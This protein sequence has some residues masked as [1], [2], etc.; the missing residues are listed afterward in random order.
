VLR[1]IRL[2]PGSLKYLDQI[3][4][5]F[6]FLLLYLVL[7]AAITY[8]FAVLAV[9]LFAGSVVNPS[10]HAGNPQY[11]QEQHAACDTFEEAYLIL[12]QLTTQNN[13]NEVNAIHTRA[14]GPWVWFFFGTYIFLVSIV[15]QDIVTGVVMDAF[16]HIHAESDA[17]EEGWEE[18]EEEEEEGGGGGEGLRM[19]AAENE[20]PTM[21][22]R[23]LRV[24]KAATRFERWFGMH[25]SDITEKESKDAIRW[26][27][28]ALL[29]QLNAAHR[30]FKTRERLASLPGKTRKS[31]ASSRGSLPPKNRNNPL[32]ELMDEEEDD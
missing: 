18:E 17:E 31:L 14:S 3:L 19:E 26:H 27:A 4:R 21:S 2:H 13:W 6:D 24:V 16:E 25:A 20:S 11:L 9:E 7:Y 22:M 5:I 23:R 1:L 10:A 32:Q 15:F 29:D 28:S 30:R 8:S 12:F